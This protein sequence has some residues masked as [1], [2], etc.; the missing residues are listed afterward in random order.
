M[1]II[2]RE[3]NPPIPHNGSLN[4]VAWVDGDEEEGVY[5]YGSTQLEAL[6]DLSWL[7]AELEDEHLND[8]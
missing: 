1:K 4:Y 5:G 6:L 8:S 2:V 7:L 3:D